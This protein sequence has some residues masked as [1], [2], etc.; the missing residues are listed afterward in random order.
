MKIKL[1]GR[2]F[3]QFDI[4]TV[5]GLHIGGSDTGIEIGG[6]DK[7]VIRDPLTGRP[8]IPGSSLKGKIRSL[9]EKYRGLEQNTKIGKVYIHSCKKYSDYQ[10]CTICQIF[11]IPGGFVDEI[12]EDNKAGG[13][14]R[15][16]V[17]DTHLDD[18]EAERIQAL[19]RMDLPFSEIKTEVAIDR[20]TSAA[21]PRQ[22]E[23]VIAG[24]TFSNGQIVLSIFDID[25]KGAR[26][27]I[28]YLKTIVEGMQLVEDDYL[29]GLGSRGSGRIRFKNIK[30]NFRG[31]DDYLIEKTPG[32]D[33]G[34]TTLESLSEDVKKIQQDVL[35]FL[36]LN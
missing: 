10:N 12:K 36:G 9:L 14:T 25:G 16:I 17:R 33:A 32:K 21:S 2:I 18:N 30:L 6:V 20:V 11:G 7:I 29:G 26:K 23:R 4:E 15:I 1:I 24:T 35:E 27:D 34:Y 31:G 3:I 28:G 5:T 22:M 19:A 13:P 8:Y